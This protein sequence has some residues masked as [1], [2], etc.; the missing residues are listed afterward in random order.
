M[1]STAATFVWRVRWTD[2]DAG[3]CIEW[4]AN[5][6]EARRRLAELGAT[7]RLHEVAIPTDRT[8]LAVW[9]N[10]NLARDNG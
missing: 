9:L 3:R 6:A 1:T 8:R 10:V 4:Y 5:A 2:D 7:A